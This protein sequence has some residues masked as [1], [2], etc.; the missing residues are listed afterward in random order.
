MY[1][2]CNFFTDQVKHLGFISDKSGI[3]PNSEKI[4]VISNAPILKDIYV[5]SIVSLCLILLRLW[6]HYIHYY[7]KMRYFVGRMKIRKHL[8]I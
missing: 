5:I 7:R 6:L 8:K 1:K 2:K 4:T 3:H